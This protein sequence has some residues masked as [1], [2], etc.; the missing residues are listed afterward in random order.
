M[1]PT[2]FGGESGF[3]QI[4]LET[5]GQFTG[6][7]SVRINEERLADGEWALLEP[8]ADQRMVLGVPRMDRLKSGRLVEVFFRG[9]VYHFGTLFSGQVFDRER[10]LEVGQFVEDGDATF[11]LDSNQRLWVLNWGISS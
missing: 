11:R 9:R 1:L 7:D 8:L 4:A 3:D 10:L 6:V 2:F 5:T